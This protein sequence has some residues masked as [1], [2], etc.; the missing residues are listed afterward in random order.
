MKRL[1]YAWRLFGTGLSFAVFGLAGLIMGL[2]LFPMMFV[3]I[4]DAGARQV[5][6][7]NLVGGSFSAFIWLMKSLGVLSYRIQGAENVCSS[8]NQLIIAN[9]PTLID[10]VFLVSLF[11]QA[12]CVIKVA[13]TKNLFMRSTV[14]AANYISYSEPQELLDSCI[15]SLE[16]GGSLILFP[17]GTRSIRRQPLKFKQDAAT[18]AIGSGAEILPIVIQCTPP[19]LVKH[20]PWYKIPPSRPFFSIQILTPI[21]LEELVPSDH[22]PRQARR[23]LNKTFLALF[24]R[25]LS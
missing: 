10:V 22:N 24:A 6:A 3:F 9:H 18:V 23:A 12:N 14:A 13:V 21:S 25:K 1:D 15:R 2:M 7:R 16:S 4:R 19:T 11:P 20:E 8:R 5:A 17:E